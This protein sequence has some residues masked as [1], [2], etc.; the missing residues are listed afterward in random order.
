M[1]EESIRG[2]NG[3]GKNTIKICGGRKDPKGLIFNGTIV[4]PLQRPLFWGCSPTQSFPLCFLK[5]VSQTCSSTSFPVFPTSGGHPRPFL[6]SPCPE[7]K[8]GRL[9]HL[10][11]FK[12]VHLSIIIATDLIQAFMFYPLERQHDTEINTQMIGYHRGYA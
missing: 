11:I 3:N 5:S 1:G 8:S 6:H 9:C 2:L 7:T 10:D 4:L 12:P